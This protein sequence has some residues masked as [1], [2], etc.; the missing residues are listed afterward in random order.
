M[1]QHD[2]QQDGETPDLT[3][4]GG[5]QQ[6]PPDK[7][8]S[9]NDGL[10]RGW[11]QFE[12]DVF[13]A[14]R[15]VQPLSGWLLS[16]LFGL[17]TW[18]TLVYAPGAFERARQAHGA[19]PSGVITMEAAYFAIVTVALLALAVAFEPFLARFMGARQKALRKWI[20]RSSAWVRRPVTWLGQAIWFVWQLPSWALSFID[21]LLARPIA[22]AVGTSLQ[23][24]LRR[25]ACGAI[26]IFAAI[27]AG[28]Y[29]PAPWGLYAV[30]AGMIAIIAIVRRWSW[31]EADRETFL[32]ERGIRK[33]AM[34]VGFDEDLRDEALIALCALISGRRNQSHFG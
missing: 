23:G 26:V 20:G 6:L 19:D 33:G 13:G 2:E 7:N 8:E 9:R 15:S 14:R 32:V 4:E 24:W 18:L 5:E 11:A 34:R 29:A 16:G 1:G 30:G 25:Y 21:Y 22:V 12:A 27:A 10:L 31:S 28:F 17:V 3:D